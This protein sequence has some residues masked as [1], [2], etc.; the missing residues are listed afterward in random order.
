MVADSNHVGGP[1]TDRA[2]CTS[3]GSPGA[4]ESDNEMAPTVSSSGGNTSAVFGFRR[5]WLGGIA[6]ILALSVAAIGQENGA[7]SGARGTVRG[8][9]TRAAVRHRV[10]PRFADAVA[11]IES[12]YDAHAVSP[13]GAV[14]VMQLMPNSA[15][16]LGV[17]PWDYRQNIEAGVRYLRWLLERYKGD[18]R[19]TL[20]AY[21]S[22]TGAVELYGGIPPYQETRAYVDSVLSEYYGRPAPGGRMARSAARSKPAEAHRCSGVDVAFDAAGRLYYRSCAGYP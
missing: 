7:A 20:A 9:I 18:V 5:I 3:T 8:E 22:G 19:R 6:V 16:K 11:K 13:K 10:D 21:N 1:R 2:E 15:K 12:G 14:G 4:E 17:N